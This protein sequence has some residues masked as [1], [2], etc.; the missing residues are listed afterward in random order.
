[1]LIK[2][3]LTEEEKGWLSKTWDTVKHGFQDPMEDYRKFVRK[4][5]NRLG[6]QGTYR[7]LIKK[8]PDAAPTDLKKA[9]KLE[10]G[11]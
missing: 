11:A 3:L 8:F 1:M 7:K 10:I 9:I 4:Y 5:I 2:E 6:S